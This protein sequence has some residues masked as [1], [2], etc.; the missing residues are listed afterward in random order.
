MQITATIVTYNEEHNLPRVLDS[1][2]CCDEIVIVD[3]HSTDG[4]AALARDRGVRVIEREWPGYAAQ[5]N[6]AASQSSHDWILALD[7]DEELSAGLQQELAALQRQGARHDAYAFPRLAQYRGKWIR[8]SGW[9]PDRKIRLYDRNKASW[10][11]D[12]VHESVQTQGTVGE[13]NGD[14]L[15]YTCPTL[16]RH[17]DTVNRYTSLAAREALAGGRR[18]GLAKLIAGPPW[19]FLRTY[20]LQAGFL[21]GREGFLI[22][23]MA[24]FYAFAKHAKTRWPDP[25]WDEGRLPRSAP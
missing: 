16:A 22:A 1:L 18:P 7:A 14:L 8:H 5:K 3:S 23:S 9:Y 25:A 11:G 17:I 20:L 21:D 10:I 6:F 4:T 24:A 2:R 13:L 12:Y 19:T 15:H